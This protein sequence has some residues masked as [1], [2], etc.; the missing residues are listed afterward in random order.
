MIHAAPQRRRNPADSKVRPARADQ[1]HK[2]DLL[3]FVVAGLFVVTAL[4]GV[5]RWSDADAGAA[6]IRTNGQAAPVAMPDAAYAVPRPGL[7]IDRVYNLKQPSIVSPSLQLYLRLRTEIEFND[8]TG[9]YA[10]AGTAERNDLQEAFLWQHVGTYAAFNDILTL[11]VA[12]HRPSQ[13]ET[14]DGKE[15]LRQELIAKFNQALA[16]TNE[17]VVY[18]NF[19]EFQM[20]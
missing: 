6:Q 5:W 13:L 19:L 12:E 7:I 9:R 10:A 17:Q 3:L 4:V 15:A 2:P 8:L 20:Q 1:P 14:A 11:T 18:I 16:G